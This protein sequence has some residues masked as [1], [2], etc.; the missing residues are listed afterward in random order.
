MIARALILLAI[1]APATLSVAAPVLGA[2]VLVS[3]LIAAPMALRAA[4][5]APGESADPGSPLDL[6]FV[7]RLALI[8]GVVII[9]ARIASA[10]WGEAGLLIFTGIAGLVDVDAITLAVAQQVRDGLSAEAGVLAALVAVA[11]NTLA[12]TVFAAA[13]GRAR[14]SLPYGAASIAALGAGVLALWPP[15]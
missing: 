10:V 13:I 15:S 11:A 2:A 6:K 5:Q 14:F 1:L 3:T 4:G 12:K 8:L 7:A 9:L